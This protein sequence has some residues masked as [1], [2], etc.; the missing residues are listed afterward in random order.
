MD[1]EVAHTPIRAQRECLCSKSSFLL[2]EFSKN[3]RARLKN[4]ESCH[5]KHEGLGFIQKDFN[6]LELGK[7]ED[8]GSLKTKG[9]SK[10]AVSCA[11]VNAVGGF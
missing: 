8:V 5:Q 9:N 3:T 11:L 4:I 2:K 6:R 1:S 7:E 10:K